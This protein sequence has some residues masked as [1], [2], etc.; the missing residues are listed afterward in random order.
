MKES[1]PTFESETEGA[2]GSQGDKSLLLLQKLI[3]TEYQIPRAAGRSGV[4]NSVQWKKA[5]SPG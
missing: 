5:T 4:F 1:N 2:W 3:G